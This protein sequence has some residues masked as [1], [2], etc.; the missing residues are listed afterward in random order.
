[1]EILKKKKKRK[2]KE[3]KKKKKK[4]KKTKSQRKDYYKEPKDGRY[5]LTLELKSCH[6][7]KES[8][9]YTENSSV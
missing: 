5:L 3:K 7:S 2:K 4:M 9:L 6:S 8:I 1:M